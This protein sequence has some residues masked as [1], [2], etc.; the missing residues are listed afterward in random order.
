MDS[1]RRLAPAERACAPAHIDWEIE[2]FN[3][4]VFWAPLR[5]REVK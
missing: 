2:V 4:F 3:A 1:R 5:I